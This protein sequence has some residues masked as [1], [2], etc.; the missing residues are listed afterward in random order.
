MRPNERIPLHDHS[1]SNSGGPV[2]AASIT[3]AATGAV[4]LGGGTSGGSSTPGVTDHGALTGLSDDDHTQYGPKVVVQET[5]GTSIETTLDTIVVDE[6][7]ATALGSGNVQLRGLPAGTIGASAVETTAQSVADDT[8]AAMT[9]DDADRFDTDGF[10]STSS[11]TSRMTIPAGLAGKYLARAEV[12]FAADA[13]GYRSI[14][15]KVTG[16]TV[17]HTRVRVASAGS[18]VATG[19]ATLAILD[20]AAGDYVETW[21]RHTAGAATNVT[22]QDF[23][24]IKLDSGRVGTGIGAS[25]YRSTNATIT[26]QTAV[27][28]DTEVFDPYGFHSTST[29][30]DRMTVPTGLGGKYLVTAYLWCTGIAANTNHVHGR[31][32]KNGTGGTAFAAQRQARSPDDNTIFTVSGIVDLVAGDYVN[33]TIE[34][35]DASFTLNTGSPA[36]LPVLTIMRLDSLPPTEQ[37]TWQSYTPTLTATTTNPTIGNGS[38]I[39][40]FLMLGPKTVMLR[41]Y[42][43]FGSTSTAGSGTYAVSLPPGLTGHATGRQTLA[44]N[45]TDAGTTHYAGVC[46]IS[47]SATTIS[48][49]HIADSTAPRLLTHN[50]PMTWATNDELVVQG[51]YEL[52]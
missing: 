46:R 41:I 18:A 34:S 1:D 49:F 7:V 50:A 48:E 52:A 4:G 24:I 25:A 29:N 33:M 44:V 8:D 27:T 51:V 6:G 39:G 16:A 5:D 31:L 43:I 35:D 37:G 11:N 36:P 13:D 17:E 10:H 3:V 14:F 26:A 28:L 40:R 32:W 42:F 20:L 9:A 45:L 21:V 38:I 12:S 47:P 22:L 19:L 15:F 2:K 23:T 30:T